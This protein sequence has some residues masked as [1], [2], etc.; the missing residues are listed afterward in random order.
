LIASNGC[1]REKPTRSPEGQTQA[2]ATLPGL[3]LAESA[4]RRPATSTTITQFATLSPNTPGQTPSPQ[5]ATPSAT[6]FARIQ[7]TPLSSA[8]QTLTSTRPPSRATA[9]DPALVRPT[10]VSPTIDA[11]PT[12]P[13]QT[14]TAEVVEILTSL[15]TIDPTRIE[16]TRSVDEEP[17]PKTLGTLRI[18]M[19]LVSRDQLIVGGQTSLPDGVCIYTKLSAGEDE[20][21]WWPVDSCVQTADNAWQLAI[22]LGVGEVPDQLDDSLDY[23]LEAWADVEPI[24]EAAPFSFDVSGPPGL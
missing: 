19:V 4:T 24:I 11:S 23:L 20:I 3:A 2:T 12:V 6:S 21:D 18:D 17:L 7:D 8:S 10:D 13:A 1:S 5:L 16:V 14:Q 22:T 9:F 15:P